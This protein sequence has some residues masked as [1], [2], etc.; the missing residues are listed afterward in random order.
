M[1]TGNY[2]ITGCVLYWWHELR[3]LGAQGRE[4]TSHRAGK[5]SFIFELN[6]EIKCDKQ[7]ILSQAYSS[8]VDLSD[9]SAESYSTLKKG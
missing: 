8:R 6:L 1:E 5:E 2:Y 3:T 7:G 9:D 4:S